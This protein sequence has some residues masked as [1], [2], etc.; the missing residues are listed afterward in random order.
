MEKNRKKTLIW[1]DVGFITIFASLFFLSF[2]DFCGLRMA[3]LFEPKWSG[4][5]IFSV[6][7]GVLI[8]YYFIIWG[9][10]KTKS[11][12]IRKE[13]L[14]SIISDAFAFVGFRKPSYKNLLLITISMILGAILSFLSL[15]LLVYLS[16]GTMIVM[17][18][19]DPL[20]VLNNL[21]VPPILEETMF[22]GIYLSV[23]LKIVGKNNAIATLGV[24]M[25]SFTFG[26]I[27][28]YMPMLKMLGGLLL[29]SIYLFKW[30][31]NLFASMSAH[32]G[33]NVVSSFLVISVV[34]S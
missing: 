25:S 7:S 28:P 26:W 6:I 31:K 5:S 14:R 9:F 16:K 21:I 12:F 34:S 2:L 10:V 22:R 3:F 1:N 30:N 11:R 18:F 19:P 27:H 13:N 29:G 15:L 4:M 32:L 33:A 17:V 8:G 24:I 20:T 23:F